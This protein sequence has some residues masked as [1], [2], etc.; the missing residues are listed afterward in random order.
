MAVRVVGNEDPAEGGHPHEANNKEVEHKREV[1]A[2]ALRPRLGAV[3]QLESLW[4]VAQ[5]SRLERAK[6]HTN[7]KMCL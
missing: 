3:V 6:S 2:V 7:I 1:D 4:S 5:G